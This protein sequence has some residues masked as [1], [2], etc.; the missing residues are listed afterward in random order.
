MDCADN[1]EPLDKLSFEAISLSK[2]GAQ[3]AKD[4]VQDAI[5]KALMNK[6]KSIRDN[7]DVPFLKAKVKTTTENPSSLNCKFWKILR[8]D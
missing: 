8:M 4:I 7:R 1:V 2:S 6:Y 3:G 5:D